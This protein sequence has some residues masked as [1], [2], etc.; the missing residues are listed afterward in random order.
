[1]SFDALLAGHFAVV[2]CQLSLSDLGAAEIAF[3]LLRS[4]SGSWFVWCG[5]RLSAAAA[6]TGKDGQTNDKRQETRAN[7]YV[8]AQPY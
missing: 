1:M 7:S 8:L 3:R 4:D 6:A 5:R 2:R